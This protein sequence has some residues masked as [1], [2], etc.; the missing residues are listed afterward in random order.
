M[1][2]DLR[3]RELAK[4]AVNYS[5][6][7]KPKQKIII[8]GGTEAIPFIVEL[9]KEAILKGAYPSVKIGLPNTSQ[10]FY[11]Y[12][13]PHQLN[14]FPQ[15]YF[16]EVKD[17]WAIA[18][19]IKKVDEQIK[20]YLE[21]SKKIFDEYSEKKDASIITI[22]T[23]GDK[24]AG[25]ATWEEIKKK[26]KTEETTVPQDIVPAEKVPNFQKE[27][28]A[29]NEIAEEYDYAPVSCPSGFSKPSNI[30]V[31]SSLLKK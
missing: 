25:E 23:V 30:A 7:V 5:V 20:Q 21:A 11:K 15:H 10:F 8:S 17:A 14:Y 2:L 31:L 4:I 28:D 13:K 1:P 27:L 6:E 22:S 16:D 24:I 29:L 18:K 12:A 26:Y 19:L 3:T 9:Y